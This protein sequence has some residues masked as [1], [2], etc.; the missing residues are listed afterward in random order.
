[1]TR[2]PDPLDTEQMIRLSVE[3]FAAPTGTR[4]ISTSHRTMRTATPGELVLHLPNGAVV[5]VSTD[6]SRTATQIEE[7]HALHAVVRPR[8]IDRRSALPRLG[9]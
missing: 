4:L 1:M 7:D 6:A 8:A 2:R 5:K 3:K 9:G